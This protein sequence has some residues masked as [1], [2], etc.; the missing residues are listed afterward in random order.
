GAQ[1][2]QDDPG[3]AHP[4]LGDRVVRGGRLGQ[5]V[6]VEL[7]SLRGSPVRRAVGAT[8]VVRTLLTVRRP[9][10]GR[11]PVVV[12]SLLAVAVIVAS[13]VR[14]EWVFVVPSGVPGATGGS[15]GVPRSGG[16]PRRGVARSGSLLAGR[17]PC[18]LRVGLPVS[19][20]ASSPQ[21]SSPGRSSSRQRMS[22]PPRGAVRG[23]GFRAR[24]SL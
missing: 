10:A 6:G 2:P 4:T 19:H 3:R 20:G 9:L 17:V 13:L 12:P 5:G 21:R 1:E 23:R 24:W 8:L 16:G 22:P 11:A 14:R 15:G 7:G 18:G